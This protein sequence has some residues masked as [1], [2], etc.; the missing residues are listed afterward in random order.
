[1]AFVNDYLSDD[2]MEMFKKLNIS[3]PDATGINGIIGYSPN[4]YK[5]KVLRETCTID[6]E[7]EIYFY[8]CGTERYDKENIPK[9][10]YFYLLW[11]EE[12]GNDILTIILERERKYDNE[13][14]SEKIIFWKKKD[15]YF[16][17]TDNKIND[18]IILKIKEAL[19]VYNISGDPDNKENN[20]R[21][22][23]DF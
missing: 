3:Y 18:K 5:F 17:L 19:S 22:D 2:E 16:V 13:N 6:R 20:R 15:I 9:M 14:H 21:V 1:M 23:F 4:A 7:A 12:F 11:K 8:Y 10:Q